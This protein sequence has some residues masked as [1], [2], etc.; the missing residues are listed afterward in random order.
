MKIRPC[1]DLHKGRVKQIV[2]GSL[3][4]INNSAKENFVSDKDAAY[5]AGLY[6][7]DKMTGGHIIKLGP[8]NESEAEN[9]LQTYPSGLQVGGGDQY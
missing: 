4:D 2:G 1:I 9:A 3:D 5:Y 6:K 8:G 7:R